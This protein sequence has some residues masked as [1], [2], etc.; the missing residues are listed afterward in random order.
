MLIRKLLKKP[1]LAKGVHADEECSLHAIAPPS[2][3]ELT[4]RGGFNRW[5]T[6]RYIGGGDQS[7]WF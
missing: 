1:S 7:S 3:G 6:V 4:R 5:W 2:N